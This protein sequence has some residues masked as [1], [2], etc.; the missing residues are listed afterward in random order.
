MLVVVEVAGTEDDAFGAP[1]LLTAGSLAVRTMPIVTILVCLFLLFFV[2]ESIYRDTAT[3]FDA[4]VYSSP[5]SNGAILLGK[6]LAAAV[7]IGVLT[8]ACGASG[9]LLL[10]LQPGGRVELWPLVLVFA[11]VLA[12]TYLLWTAFVTAIMTVVRQRSAAL[13][14][15]LAAL[16]LTGFQFASGTMTWASN[17]PLWGALR[18]SDLGTFPLNGGAL[19]LNRAGAMA[20]AVFL[21]AIAFTFLTRTERDAVATFER[22]RPARLLRGALRL[23]P[24]ALM[25]VLVLGFLGIQVRTGFQGEMAEERAREHWRRNVATWR[26]VVPADITHLDVKLDLEPSERR[27]RVQGTY[28]MVNATGEPMRWLTFTVGESFGKVAWTMNGR[29]VTPDDRGRSAHPDAGEAAAAGTGDARGVR[30]HRDLSQGH[31]PQRRRREH[32]HPAGGR[33]ALDAP[34]RVPAGAGVRRGY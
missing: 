11:L 17:W 33:P 24:F 20:L 26:D 10:M 2:I 21:F 28:S 15:G 4:L 31:H 8:V 27:M 23:A 32:L 30:L 34:R 14:L 18:W 3:K 12:P 5:V 6:G 22:L 7:V 13:A 1:V 25:P 16:V 19:M 9:L 29:P